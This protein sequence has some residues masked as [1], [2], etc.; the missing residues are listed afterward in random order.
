MYPSLRKPRTQGPSVRCQGTPAAPWGA[1]L[2]W[3]SWAHLVA[4]FNEQWMTSWVLKKSI[5]WEMSKDLEQESWPWWNVLDYPSCLCWQA[6]TGHEGSRNKI[7][8]SDLH[9][10]ISQEDWP[11]RHQIRVWMAVWKVAVSQHLERHFRGLLKNSADYLWCQWLSSVCWLTS[12]YLKAM[13]MPGEGQKN[14][15]LFLTNPQNNPWGVPRLPSHRALALSCSHSSWSIYC[16][17]AK[18]RGLSRTLSGCIFFPTPAA[19][20]DVLFPDSSITSLCYWLKFLAS[21]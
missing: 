14:V 3:W 11:L 16:A 7:L 21:F 1:V 10:P 15:H 8:G 9:S 19:K 13:E 4:V 20:V 2:C 18:G 6:Q 17:P 12:A 5:Y